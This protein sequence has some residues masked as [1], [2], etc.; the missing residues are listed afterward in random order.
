MRNS[1]SI[2]SEKVNLKGN[3][4]TLVNPEGS[5]IF[6]FELIFSFKNQSRELNKPLALFMAIDN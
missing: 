6:Q 3:Y 4:S 5:L 1:Y 2:Q